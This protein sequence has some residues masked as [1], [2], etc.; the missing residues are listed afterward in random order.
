MSDLDTLESWWCQPDEEEYPNDKPHLTTY[1]RDGIG[2][3]P[4]H[5]VADGWT[6]P[7]K[8]LEPYLKDFVASEKRQ[9]QI[10]EVLK[11]PGKSYEIRKHVQDRLTALKEQERVE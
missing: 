7:W 2:G 5:P 11:I 8:E 3:C 9:A 6:I 10:E 1:Q 4:K